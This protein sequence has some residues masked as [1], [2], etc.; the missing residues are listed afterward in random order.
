MKIKKIYILN[1]K[2]LIFN[3][4]K[5]Y[6]YSYII[7]YMKLYSK[8]RNLNDPDKI[9]ILEHFKIFTKGNL[10]KKN[11]FFIKKNIFLL[12]IN[13]GGKITLHTPGQLIFY[14]LLNIKRLKINIYNLINILEN[15]FLDVLF[16]HGIFAYKIK[17]H[18]VYINYKNQE[19]KIASLGLGISK[20]C[21]F[22]G[23]SYNI[24]FNLNIFK[25]FKPCDLINIKMIKLCDI[26]NFA[27]KFELEANVGVYCF[28]K[29]IGKL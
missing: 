23:L 13:R 14:I 15:T 19:Y 24:N 1:T 29:H 16:F 11:I 5:K 26:Y 21:S 17:N 6:N 18:G 7:K 9:L 4:L 10:D 20:G 3:C 22:H 8:Y 25:N 28:L 27:I 12:K 2:I